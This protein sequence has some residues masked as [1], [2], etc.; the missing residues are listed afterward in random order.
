M[1]HPDGVAR[2]EPDF[3]TRDFGGLVNRFVVGVW[4]IRFLDALLRIG[5]LHRP[6]LL[7]GA[8]S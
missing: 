1:D 5:G 3:D 2:G 4:S 8:D 7:P 6:A